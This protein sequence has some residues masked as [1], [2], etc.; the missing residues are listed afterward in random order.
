MIIRPYVRYMSM[1]IYTYSGACCHTCRRP[2]SSDS[3]M[4]CPSRSRRSAMALSLSLSLPPSL[5]SPS[6]S[7]L[8]SNLPGRASGL[9][10]KLGEGVGV[11][12]EAGAGEGEGAAVTAAH[13]AF[14]RS[15]CSNPNP[16]PSLS[17]SSC[18]MSLASMPACNSSAWHLA[19]SAC[20][21]GAHFG[22]G[23]GVVL[24]LSVR[25]KATEYAGVAFSRISRHGKSVKRNPTLTLTLP[26]MLKA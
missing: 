3:T 10:L 9:G 15:S 12:V 17:R 14:S 1:Y 19:A 26:G 4:I 2:S 20:I 16:S 11:R 23:G 21:E 8:S 5:A 24:R 13:C 7:L 6:P 25:L 22:W 18:S